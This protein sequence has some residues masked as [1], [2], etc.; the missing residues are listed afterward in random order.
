M[1]LRPRVSLTRTAPGCCA[2]PGAVLHLR[3]ARH[4]GSALPGLCRGDPDAVAE[5]TAGHA[6]RHWCC[7]P[8]SCR[9]ATRSTPRCRSWIGPWPYS[10]EPAGLAHAGHRTAGAGP[11]RRGTVLR[12]A[13]G[14]RRGRSAVTTLCRESLRSLTGHLA[15]RLCHGSRAAAAITC[16]C[17][18]RLALLGARRD[19]RA[20]RSTTPTPNTGSREG[21]RWRRR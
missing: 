19:G 14:R 6:R 13:P 4:R 1:S 9:A 15:I 2:A 8:R 18:A 10:R 16:R 11:L 3:A 17:R 7:T 20:P 12:V 21:L 5:P